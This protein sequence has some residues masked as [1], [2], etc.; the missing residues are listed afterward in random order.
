MNIKRYASLLTL[1]ACFGPL[2]RAQ[3][4]SWDSPDAYLGQTRPS[5]TPIVFA[6]G[7]LA[8]RGT[9][10][11]DRIAFSNDGKEIYHEQSDRWFS[12]EHATIKTVK[13]AGHKWFIACHGREALNKASNTKARRSNR[14]MPRCR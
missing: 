1:T 10:T 13:Y 2:L 9:F 7:R 4:S 12:L 5:E 8:D 3:E 14:P 11:L 6:P